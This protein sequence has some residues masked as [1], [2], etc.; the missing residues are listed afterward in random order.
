[1]IHNDSHVSFQPPAYESFG[2]VVRTF[3]QRSCT[4]LLMI[5]DDKLLGGK[6]FIFVQIFSY[7]II[8]FVGYTH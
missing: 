7:V 3:D 4:G 1:M 2:K 6:G 5:N 8:W